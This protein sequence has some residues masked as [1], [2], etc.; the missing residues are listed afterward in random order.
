MGCSQGDPFVVTRVRVKG[1]LLLTVM[2]AQW[3]RE[4]YTGV[5]LTRG[6]LVVIKL[7]AV[8][9]LVGAPPFVCL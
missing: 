2:W 9:S 5:R 7:V 4:A 3:H 8:I 6:T 1:V